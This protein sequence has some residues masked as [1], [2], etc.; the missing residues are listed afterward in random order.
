M[1]VNN[2]KWGKKISSG[3][4]QKKRIKLLLAF[5]VDCLVSCWFLLLVLVWVGEYMCVS[6]LRACVYVCSAQKQTLKKW[7]KYKDFKN[8]DLPTTRYSFCHILWGRHW[9]LVCR[10]FALWFALPSG[11]SESGQSPRVIMD[12]IGRGWKV[13]PNEL[14]LSPHKGRGELMR[15]CWRWRLTICED[16][17]LYFLG[18]G[19]LISYFIQ[20]LWMEILVAEKTWSFF[21]FITERKMTNSHRLFIGWLEKA[22][23][24]LLN[25]TSLKVPFPFQSQKIVFIYSSRPWLALS[26]VNESSQS[27]HGFTHVFKRWMINI[28]EWLTSKFSRSVSLC[29]HS[30]QRS[31][32]PKS[33]RGKILRE[34]FLLPDFYFNASA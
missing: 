4:W 34:L 17:V 28:K 11:T 22:W 32:S 2:L 29:S 25:Q 8:I 9:F 15:N 21:S 5:V 30:P 20:S 13:F 24:D 14:G 16:F 27:K 33:E 31:L 23:F 7:R 3:K 1:L 6:M 19:V 18:L 12:L 26:Q 10:A